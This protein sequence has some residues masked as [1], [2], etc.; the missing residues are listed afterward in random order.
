MTGMHFVLMFK[1]DVLGTFHKRHPLD[2]TLG[3][4]YDV[5]GMFQQKHKTVKE[6][7]L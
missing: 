6:L 4:L 1:I 2:S 3:R 7:T 5:F